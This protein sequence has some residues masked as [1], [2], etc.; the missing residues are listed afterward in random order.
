VNSLERYFH[1]NKGPLLNKWMHYFD[2]YDKHFSRYRNQ[3]MLMVEI[4]VYHG[5]SLGMWKDYFGPKAKIVGV[6]INPR[7]SCFA[8]DQVEIV[9]GDQSD[10]G[11]LRSLREQY[12]NVDILLD[13]GGHSMNQQIVTFEE[14]FDAVADDGVYMVEDVHTSY[15]PEYGGG[16]NNPDSFIEYSKKLI[17]ELNAWHIREWKD[18][19]KSMIAK[20]AHSISFYDSVIAIE[21][22]NIPP[23]E[24]H[25]TGKMSFLSLD[26]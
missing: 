20:A 25:M 5:G 26:E 8:D 24:A 2:I 12:P 1:A 10:R 19:K 17:D 22:R 21:K 23:P 15:W 14:M 9:I 4:G 6:D 7:A 16:L 13:D 11:F 18:R 3:S